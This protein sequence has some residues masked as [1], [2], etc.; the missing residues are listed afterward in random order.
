MLHVEV[1]E[2]ANHS[3]S[4]ASQRFKMSATSDKDDLVSAASQPRT[5]ICTHRASAHHGDTHDFPSLRVTLF[6]GFADVNFATSMQDRA[7]AI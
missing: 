6:L 5:E 7:L 3:Q 2:R 4:V 1:P